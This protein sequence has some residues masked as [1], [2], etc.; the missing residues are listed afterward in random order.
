MVSRIASCTSD[1]GSSLRSG[2]QAVGMYVKKKKKM[3]VRTWCNSQ[4]DC[5]MLHVCEHTDY[6]QY[7]KV[8]EII[9]KFF[10]IFTSNYIFLFTQWLPFTGMKVSDDGEEEFWGFCPELAEALSKELNFTW[11]QSHSFDFVCY[12]TPTE[13][14]YH[15]QKDTQTFQNN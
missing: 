9:C 8:A 2:I 12:A 5:C 11:V 4:N 13:K 1:P 6:L 10:V 14:N 7:A 15:A 3:E